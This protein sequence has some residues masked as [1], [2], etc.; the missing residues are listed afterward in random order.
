MI[1]KGAEIITN[2][3]IKNNEIDKADKELYQYALYSFFLTLSPM[4][5]AIVLGGVM[6][7]L[8]ES[9]CIILPFMFIRKFSGG[10]HAKHSG[11][12]LICS[13]LLLSL[14]IGVSMYAKCNRYLFL[15]TFFASIMLIIFSPIEHENR[16]LDHE[17]KRR[18]KIIASI[19]VLLFGIL[20]IVCFMFHKDKAALCISIGIILSAGLQVPCI[21]NSIKR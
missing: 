9:V 10:Y 11:T 15:L 18:Y 3:L 8:K 5:L 4:L 12:C 21:L 20:S 1:V 2:W 17:E 7:C 13:S 6:G 19:L 16:R 14:C